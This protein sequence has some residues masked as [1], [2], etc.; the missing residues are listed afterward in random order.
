MHHPSDQRCY[1]RAAY[2]GARVGHAPVPPPL[3]DRRRDDRGSHRFVHPGVGEDVRGIRPRVDLAQ[4]D[5]P[6]RHRLPQHRQARGG[7][8]RLA[9]RAAHGHAGE[10]ALR[11]EV[12]GSGLSSR[13]GGARSRPGQSGRGGARS[14]RGLSGRSARGR[15][16]ASSRVS[17]KPV[18]KVAVVAVSVPPAGATGSAPL[19]FLVRR[20]D[21]NGIYAIM[22]NQRDVVEGA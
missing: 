17:I 1:A 9:R 13:H 2:G 14:R 10:L 22:P 20:I 11:E 16:S 8:A 19:Q 18:H 6:V 3:V 15:G 5:D 7:V 12:A 21:D 4:N